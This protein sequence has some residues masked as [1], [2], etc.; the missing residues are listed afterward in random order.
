LWVAGRIGFGHVVS[1]KD[2]GLPKLAIDLTKEGEG[3]SVS[4]DSS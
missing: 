2:G 4:I 1:G 3:N